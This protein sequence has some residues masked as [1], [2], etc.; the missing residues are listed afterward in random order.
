MKPLD[1][2]FKV[3]NADR[4]KNRGVIRIALLEIE[5]NRHKKQINAAVTDLNET[6]I[7]LGHIHG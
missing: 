3:F 1:F 2:S 7:F 4:T 5:I 6:D